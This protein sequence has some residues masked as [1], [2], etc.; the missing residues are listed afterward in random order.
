[1]TCRSTAESVCEEAILGKVKNDLWLKI[2]SS[3]SKLF[4]IWNEYG[5]DDAW[6][7]RRAKAVSYYVQYL[8]QDI[9][10]EENGY[11]EDIKHRIQ[12]YKNQILELSELLCVRTN[13]I[14]EG[15]LIQTEQ[16][17]CFEVK[18]LCKLKDRRIKVF[19]DLR[20]EESKY[21]KRLGLPPLH[22]LTTSGLASAKNIKELEQHITTLILEKDYRLRKYYAFKRELTTI[23]ETTEISP[24][25]SLEKFIISGKE[26]SILLSD[27]RMKAVEDIVCKAQN[28]KFNLEARKKELM[29]KLTTLWERLNV[30]ENEKEM[31][32]LQ[33][34]DCRVQ[35]IESIEKEVQK[36]EEIKKQNI[37]SYVENLRRELEALWN[38][39]FVSET[40]R[41]KFPSFA[42]TEFNDEILETHEVEVE[43]WSSF[44]RDTENIVNKIVKKQKLRD[45]VIVFET[46]RYK[47]RGGS[48]FQEEKERRRLQKDFT[49][50][51]NEI[52]NAINEYKAQKGKSFLYSGLDFRKLIS[53][54]LESKTKAKNMYLRGFEMFIKENM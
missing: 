38:K 52:C 2:K 43:K 23:L 24:E 32:L 19:K 15:R 20:S 12:D 27:E 40:R 45:L 34:A 5:T 26:D 31:F 39:C 16:R 53:K 17:L 36:Y 35:T 37:Q 47:N 3:F 1:M 28:K 9:I 22:I 7:S 46:S 42:A 8:L 6:K 54:R 51:E 29:D 41:Q 13:D 25:T 21:C 4:F 44:Y 10:N 48:L 49:A 18:K 30:N 14:P 50:L 11:S 33:H